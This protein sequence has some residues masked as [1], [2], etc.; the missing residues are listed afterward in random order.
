MWCMVLCRQNFDQR[1]TDWVEAE[2]QSCGGGFLL[3]AGDA[4]TLGVHCRGDKYFMLPNV[5]VKNTRPK[6]MSCRDLAV[7]IPGYH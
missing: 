7:V 5:C 1:W 3:V 6:M 2:E 4:E